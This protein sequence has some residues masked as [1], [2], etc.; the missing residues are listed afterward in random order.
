[1]IYPDC[2]PN[3]RFCRAGN[4]SKAE[5]EKMFISHQTFKGLI[6]SCN[7][8]IECVQYLI[9]EGVEY[10]LSER[11]SQDVLEEYFGNQRKLG[12]RYDNPDVDQFGHNTN[13]LRIQR[14]VSWI[15]G[16]T[17]GRYDNKRS[18]DC[19]SDEIMMKRVLKQKWLK[20]C[21]HARV[22]DRK[23]QKILLS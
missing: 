2:E 7:S 12:K 23:C 6:I 19:V 22:L 1:M 10:V 20:L 11:F 3:V 5:R 8:L 9:N 15:S 21:L 16:N 14:E 18:W 13:T 4:F 17:R